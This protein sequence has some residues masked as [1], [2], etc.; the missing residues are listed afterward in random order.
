LIIGYPNETR[1]DLYDTLL[2]AA[3][4]AGGQYSGRLVVQ[5][6]LFAPLADTPLTRSGGRFLFD[7]NAANTVELDGRLELREAALIES[8]FGLFSAF[9]H[10]AETEYER[11]DYL[12]LTAVLEY[13]FIHPALRSKLLVEERWAFLDFLIRGHF[14]VDPHT[15]TKEQMALAI[16]H[17]YG[18]GGAGAAWQRPSSADF[19]QIHSLSS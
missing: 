5:T 4:L 9:Y 17:G 2:L 19:S 8:S 3:E 14:P 16:L 7:G 12:A 13:L 11:N 15:M 10:P 18:R 1:R 6:H